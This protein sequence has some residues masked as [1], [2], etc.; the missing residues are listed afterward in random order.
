[1]GADEA[2]VRRVRQGDL[3]AFD[4]LYQRYNRRLFS[5]IL[6][7]VAERELAEDLL[8]EV[9]IAVLRDTGLDL[10]LGHFGAW[11]FTVARNACLNH[12]RNARRRESK[13]REL[14][15]GEHAQSMSPEEHADRRQK[16]ARIQAAL[17]ALP[18]PQQDALILKQVAELTY[19]QIAQIFGVP[20]G[21]IK[22][23]L[24]LAIKEMRRQV[25][26]QGEP[27]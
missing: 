23:R 8:Q 7:Y 25:A 5:Y 20:E 14:G 21:T 26:A 2:L 24:H 3:G 27:A 19:G 13:S 22:S 15:P 12:V 4:E 11:L 9:F 1:M 6:R 16:M 17:A 18:E 10:E